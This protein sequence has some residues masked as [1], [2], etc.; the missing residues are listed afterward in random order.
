LLPHRK[1]N[2]YGLYVTYG[3]DL[4]SLKLRNTAAFVTQIAQRASERADYR[5]EFLLNQRER[6]VEAGGIVLL[7]AK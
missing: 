4:W 2:K 7:H 5:E 3:T 1:V 6:M